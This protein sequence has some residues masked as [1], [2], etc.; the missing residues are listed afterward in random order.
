MRG[1][2]LR[3][4]AGP[5]APPAAGAGGGSVLGDGVPGGGGGRSAEPRGAVPGVRAGSPVPAGRRQARP[6]SKAPAR[7]CTPGAV[8]LREAVACLDFGEGFRVGLL[9]DS[10]TGK[11][12]AAVALV[13]EYLRRSPGLVVVADVKGEGRFGGQVYAT[14]S[15]IADRPPDPNAGRVLVVRGDPFHGL[16]VEPDEVAAWSWKMAARRWRTLTVTD[17]LDQ[18]CA[19]GQWRGGKEAW[20]GALKRAFIRGRS[21]GLS[22]LWGTTVPHNVPVEAFDGSSEIWCFRMA[23]MGLALLRR[24]DYL[25][26]IDDETIEGLPG[27]PLPPAERGVFVRLRRGQPWDGRLYK[28]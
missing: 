7:D 2:R 6:V 20:R 12:T 15:D 3:G 1:G 14:V 23:G 21:H 27:E 22:Q 17:E 10:G 4:A 24:R 9:G 8:A 25:R 16:E 18:A 26:G 28:F 19:G 5:G 11:T 13:Q